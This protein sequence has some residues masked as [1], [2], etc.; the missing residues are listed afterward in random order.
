M[1]AI[2][3]L[4]YAGKIQLAGPLGRVL[5]GAFLNGFQDAMI[6]LIIPVPLHASKLKA[7]GF[8][9]VMVMLREWP[10]LAAG[11]HAS[12]PAIDFQSKTVIRKKKTKSQ[13]G[14]GKE[15]RKTNVR[16]AFSVLN[17]DA[18]QGKQVLLVDDVYTTGATTEECAK[19]LVKNGA[20]GVYIL[21][22]ARAG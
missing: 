2:H 18:I 21:T 22:L 6:D 9:Q 10:F 11:I 8:N 14:L 13:T 12:C 3:R 5:F 1:E 7:R 20:G 19:T 15:N 17:P 4:K 16:G